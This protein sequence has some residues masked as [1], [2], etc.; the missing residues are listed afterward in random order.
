VLVVVCV[1]L[2]ALGYIAVDAAGSDERGRL[3]LVQDLPDDVRIETDTVWHR[4][5]ARFEGRRNC[6]ADV[7][8][9]LVDDVVGGDARYVSDEALIQ[10]EIPTTP[11]RFRESLVHE[12]AHHVE[13][14]CDEFAE[15]RTVLHAAFGAEQAWTGDSP[16]VDSPSERWAETVVQLVNGERL[17]HAEEMPIDPSVVDTVAS[18]GRGG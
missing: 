14:T 5:L 15:L 4:F 13:R 11:A 3:L 12:L 17:L 10:I 16:W 2:G 18:W 9:V 6:F 1:A 8:L 7:R